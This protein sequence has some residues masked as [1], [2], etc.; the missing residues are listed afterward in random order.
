MGAES[1]VVIGGGEPT[2]YPKFK[3]LVCYL[4]NKEM[5]PVVFTHTTTMTPELATFLFKQNA[6]IIGKLDS[7]IEEKQDMFAGKKGTCRRIKMGINH[8]INADFTNEVDPLFLRLSL[9][10][11]INKANIEELPPLWH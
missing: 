9:S 6:S 1:V 8:L 5:I 2:L 11:V 4:N 10:F 3:D 7:L